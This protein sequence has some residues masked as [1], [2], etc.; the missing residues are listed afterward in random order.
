[1][2]RHGYKRDVLAYAFLALVDLVST[3]WLIQ[4]GEAV[5][6]NVVLGSWFLLTGVSALIAMKIHLTFTVMACMAALNQSGKRHLV[7]LARMVPA[8]Y[9]VSF[10]IFVIAANRGS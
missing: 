2:A 5:E 8:L 4:R 9:I 6:A 3:L 10:V 1:M 7:L